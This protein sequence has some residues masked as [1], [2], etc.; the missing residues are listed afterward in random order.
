MYSENP[1]DMIMLHSSHLPF[2]ETPALPKQ[3]DTARSTARM[4]SPTGPT[5]PT[6]ALSQSRPHV[7]PNCGRGSKTQ[8]VYTIHVMGTS[9]F[10][11]LHSRST[12][13]GKIDRDLWDFSSKGWR[14]QLFQP[15]TASG[16]WSRSSSKI[17]A[18]KINRLKTLDSK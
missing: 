5:Q 6:A 11:P 12:S 13:C 7:R 9:H 4:M 10:L 2:P 14:F 8:R 18:S 1:P 15:M 17:D 3:K 16:L